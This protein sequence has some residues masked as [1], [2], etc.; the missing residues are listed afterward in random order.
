MTILLGVIVTIIT[1]LFILGIHSR[2]SIP[3]GLV[4]GMLTKCSKKP[5]CVCSEIKRDDPHFIKPLIS[6]S[7]IDLLISVIQEMGGV[8]VNEKD[9]YFAFQFTSKIFGFVDDFEV[10]FEQN[11]NIIHFRSASRVGRSD[12]GVNRNRVELVKKLYR[13]R[14]RSELIK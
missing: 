14:L 7:N 2:K 6:S 8:L 10:R 9:N 3:S 11:K 5:N 13:E 1:L 12:L 4:D